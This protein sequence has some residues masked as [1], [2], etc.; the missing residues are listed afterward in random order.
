MEKDDYIGNKTKQLQYVI[1]AVLHQII[2][3]R[4][5]KNNLY[6]PF[7]IM[8]NALI[9][10]NVQLLLDHFSESVNKFVLE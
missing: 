1:S 9:L 6:L 2:L 8:A 4:V 10:R 5:K 3:F 7:Q